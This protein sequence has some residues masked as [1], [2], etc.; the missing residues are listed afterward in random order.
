[1][2][3]FIQIFSKTN[4]NILGKIKFKNLDPN[5]VTPRCQ[6][7]INSKNVDKLYSFQIEH[8]TKYNEFFF[9]KPIIIGNLK[10]TY[11]LL[12]GQ[13]R[14]SC[15]SYLANKF[16]SDID[17]LVSIVKVENEHELDDKYIAINKNNP[18]PL[19]KNINDWKNFGKGAEKF[20]LDNFKTY[21]KKSNKPTPPNFNVNSFNQYIIDNNVST[22]LKNNC[23]L[24]IKEIDRLNKFYSQTYT[25]TLVPHFRTNIM[26]KI[27]KT[28]NTQPNN[29]LFLTLYKN[30]EWV[31]RILYKIEKNID[32][33]QMIHIPSNYRIKIK[34]NLRRAVW[35]KY[36]QG[37]LEGNCFVC[38]KNIDYDT[39]QCGH[40]ESVFY[41]GDNSI[42]NLEPICSCCNLDMGIQNLYDYKNEYD[43]ELGIN[44]KISIE[45]TEF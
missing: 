42:L 10:D 14:L 8:Y 29:P 32:Y 15:I 12:D 34:K 13:H 26:K 41:G 24:F 17:V 3:K 19:P 6:R 44:K 38:L 28:E 30:Y 9:P 39:F 20:M 4:K 18:V 43:K 23:E 16:N 27:I 2:K 35:E 31:E 5:L 40:V 11:Y 45:Q 33:G 22:R 37:S 21:S 1:M 36:F 25:S 7:N